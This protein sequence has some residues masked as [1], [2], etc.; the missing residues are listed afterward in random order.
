MLGQPEPFLVCGLA[1]DNTTFLHHSAVSYPHE[2]TEPHLLFPIDSLQPS[3][4]LTLSLQPSLRLQSHLLCCC[5]LNPPLKFSV[6]SAPMGSMAHLVLSSSLHGTK[7]APASNCPW[8]YTCI[9]PAEPSFPDL[10]PQAP[11]LI[12]LHVLLHPANW[13]PT[14]IRG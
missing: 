2:F 3:Q 12:L 7:I 4:P 10:N 5:P 1:S 11:S 6:V 9:L 14:W 8:H 13:A